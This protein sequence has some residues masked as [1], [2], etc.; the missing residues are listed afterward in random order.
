MQDHLCQ[1]LAHYVVYLGSRLNLPIRSQVSRF[2]LEAASARW[3]KEGNFKWRNA[4]ECDFDPTTDLHLNGIGLTSSG[5]FFGQGNHQRP[6]MACGATPEDFSYWDKKFGTMSINTCAAK[7]NGDLVGYWSYGEGAC[8]RILLPDLRI[9]GGI[10]SKTELSLAHKITVR[11]RAERDDEGK[12]PFT[13]GLNRM[14][15]IYK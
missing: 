9:L 15:M 13:F 12:V 2:I 5:Q 4:S 6:A 7:F 10:L 1:I 14:L 8:F 11:D 3:Y